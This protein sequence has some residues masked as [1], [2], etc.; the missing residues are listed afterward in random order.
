MIVDKNIPKTTRSL[1]ALGAI[2]AM[3]KQEQQLIDDIIAKTLVTDLTDLARSMVWIDIHDK[4]LD[5]LDILEDVY[6][7]K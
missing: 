2:Q 5:Y 3:R 6:A 1:F 7:N 4:I